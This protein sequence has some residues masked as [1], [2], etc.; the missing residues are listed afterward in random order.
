[1]KLT[2]VQLILKLDYLSIRRFFLL[3]QLVDNINQLN[4]AETL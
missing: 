1:M 3:L 4:P 2:R